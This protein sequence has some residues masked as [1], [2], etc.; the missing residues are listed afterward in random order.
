M[1]DSGSTDIHAAIATPAKPKANGQRRR[2][3][4][5]LGAAVVAGAIGYGVYWLLV[6]SHY[7][8]TDN[9]YVGADTAQVTPL[10]SGQVVRVLV[11]ETQVV[12]AG[13][14]LVILDDA[15]A[16]IAVASAKAALDQAQR[17]VKGYF[18][19]D[20]ALAGQVAGKDAD[21]AQ[22]NAQVAGAEADLTR[23]KTDLSRRQAL[24][25][26]GAVSGDELTNAQNR[27]ASAQAALAAAK[28]MRTAAVAARG[29]AEGSRGVNSARIAGVP[30]ADN[31]D[32]LAARAR[33]DA[34]ELALSRTVISAP[35][36]GVVTKKAIEV[37]QQVQVGQQ[38]MVI[39]P[40][41]QAYVDANFK[42][43]QLE[44]VAIGQPVTLTSDYYGGGIKFHGRVKGF[45]GGTGSAFSLIPA[46]NASGNWIKIVQR[47][48]VRIT[49]DPRD[50]R[51]HPLRVGL[52]MTAV[53]D[54]SGPS[55]DRPGAPADRS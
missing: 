21:I 35:V 54:V 31:P 15:D 26:S 3:L 9:A 53:I 43:V 24:A 38:M 51:D 45:S 10:V 44:K 16:R 42:E 41:A 18:A 5:L 29:T 33:L 20:A 2:L 12:K 13:Q 4:G 37:G 25:T 48:P 8:S 19:N 27:F 36:D 55:H 23:A 22:A 7:V 11:N 1:P 14:P 46:Q 34:A 40:T 39:V 50:L 49:L 30:L 17:Q 6:A 52:S 28:A 47:L 32:V